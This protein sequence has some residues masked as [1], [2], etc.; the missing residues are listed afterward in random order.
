MQVV[1]F[2]LAATWQAIL[3][4]TAR[5]EDFVEPRRGRP[6]ALFFE[7]Y[8]KIHG[9]EMDRNIPRIYEMKTLPTPYCDDAIRATYKANE[10]LT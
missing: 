9:P 5:S 10:C 7:K 3:E 1:D 2:Q 4:K 6:S 8:R